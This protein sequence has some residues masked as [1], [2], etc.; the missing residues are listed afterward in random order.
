MKRLACLFAAA[1]LAATPAAAD[2][3]VFRRPDGRALSAAHVDAEVHASCSE[4]LVRA[5]IARVV[6]ACDDPSPFASGQG[7]ERLRAAEHR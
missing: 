7:A 2:G 5:G 1:L 6:I 3:S 4:L